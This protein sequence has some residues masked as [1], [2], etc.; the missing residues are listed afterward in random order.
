MSANEPYDRFGNVYNVTRLLQADNT[1]NLTAYE[2]YSPL[3]LPATYAM[4]YL[5]AF[6]L[7]TCVIVHTLLYH[8]RSLLNGFKNM[9]VEKDDIHAK[10]MRNYPEVPDWWYLLSF[11]FFFCLAIVAAERWH[12]GVPLTEIWRTEFVPQIFCTST[13]VSLAGSMNPP[14]LNHNMRRGTLVQNLRFNCL[15][16]VHL[17][18][19]LRLHHIQISRK[20]LH[21]FGEQYRDGTVVKE[22]VPLRIYVHE[23]L[24]ERS[25]C[26][27]A[28]CA[29]SKQFAGRSR[30]LPSRRSW[31]MRKRDEEAIM[32]Q[33]SS[34]SDCEPN[35]RP[36][37]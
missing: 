30:I 22:L 3:Y 20:Q 11:C 18:R 32:A 13:Q 5:L 23:V 19:S 9:K 31:A 21:F 28:R 6:A 27:R 36:C 29:I 17:R 35:I 15:L 4:T 8:G 14:P 24:E 34:S 16:P 10:L 26:C 25:V 1:F 2:E 37:R 12:T 33:T 7:S